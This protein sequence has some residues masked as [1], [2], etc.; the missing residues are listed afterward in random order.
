[1]VKKYKTIKGIFISDQR[2]RKK[3]TLEFFKLPEEER[4]LLSQ[5]IF[6]RD[7]LRRKALY[8]ILKRKKKLTGREYYMSALILHHSPYV[9]D[10]KRAAKYA[11]KAIQMGEDEAKWLYAAIVDGLMISQGKKQKYGTQY[12]FKNGKWHLYPVDPKTTD[13]ERKRYNV[14]PLKETLAK[15]KEWNLRLKKKKD[16]I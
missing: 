8:E 2:D 11:K 14:P 3:I 7:E 12:Q 10:S 1:M 9:E 5:K 4:K 13:E 6:Q 15:I 16:K